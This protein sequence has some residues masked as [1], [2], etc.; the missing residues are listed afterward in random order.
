MRLIIKTEDNT[1]YS[2]QLPNHMDLER[3]D[4]ILKDALFELPKGSVYK[5]HHAHSDDLCDEER[6][7]IDYYG[8]IK[9]PIIPLNVSIYETE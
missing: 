8:E 4:H 3:I 5:S 7:Q 2:V 6:K 1:L 9:Y